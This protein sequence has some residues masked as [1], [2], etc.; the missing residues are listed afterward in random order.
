[1]IKGSLNFL[2][3][4]DKLRTES[5]LNVRG[6]DFFVTTDPPNFSIVNLLTMFLH[7]VVEVLQKM[8]HISCRLIH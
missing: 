3:A 1:M 8:F 5:A 2:I 7:L 4:L 6:L